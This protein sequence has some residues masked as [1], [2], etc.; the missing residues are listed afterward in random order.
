MLKEVTRDVSDPVQRMLWGKAAGRC[1]FEGH[2]KP[3]WKSSVTQ[4]Q[5]NIAQ[6]AHIYAFSSDGPRGNE[7]IPPERLNQLENLMLVCHECH[8]AIDQEKNG[9]R[10]TAELLRKWKGDHERRIELACAIPLEKRSHVLLYGAN[11][12]DHTSPLRFG[13]AAQAIFPGRYPA[14]DKPIELGMTNSGFQDRDEAYWSV[15]SGNLVRQFD[16]RVRERLA[17]GTIEHISVFGLAPQPLLILLGALLTDIPVADVYQLRREP[18]GWSWSGAEIETSYTVRQPEVI[19]GPPALVL[20]LS[21]TIASERI[22]CVR[23]DYTVWEITIDEPHNDFL[24]TR[25]QLAS[26]RRALRS[27]LD[28][29]KARHGQEA[30]LSIFPA[31]PVA[32]AVDLGRIRMPKADL[33]WQIYDQLGERGFVHALDIPTTRRL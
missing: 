32:A 28:L 4:E 5:V 25:A 30:T 1:Q 2:N 27:L 6:K 13:P 21:A 24:Q 17:D 11:I 15:E 8:R 20:S 31:M 29:I 22:L 10:Y 9:G 19:S 12:G 7:G 26:L 23:D 33:R 18:P 14:D 16:K 3:L